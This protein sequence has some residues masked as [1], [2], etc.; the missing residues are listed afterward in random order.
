MLMVFQRKEVIITIIIIIIC[1]IHQQIC[2]AVCALHQAKHDNYRQQKYAFTW[3]P[4]SLIIYMGKDCIR[5]F[6]FKDLIARGDNRVFVSICLCYWCLLFFSV[7]VKS[8]TPDPKGDSLSLRATKSYVTTSIPE[9]SNTF[10]KS[11]LVWIA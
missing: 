1:I 6:L 8:Q 2:L 3:S 4:D 7:M 10:R 11:M 5:L 9:S